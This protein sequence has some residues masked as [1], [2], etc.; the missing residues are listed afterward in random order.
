MLKKYTYD[1]IIL[2]INLPI[3]DGRQFLKK[4]RKNNNY[5]PVIAA[6]SNNMLE[7]KLEM[8]DI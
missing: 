6:T 2:D 7:H 5:T 8:Y 1:V 3:M 4:I